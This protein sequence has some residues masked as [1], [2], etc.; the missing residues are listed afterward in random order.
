M[1]ADVF[2]S[3]LN[4]SRPTWGNLGSAAPTIVTAGLSGDED[5]GHGGLVLREHLEVHEA[6]DALVD[7]RVQV[8]DGHRAVLVVHGLQDLAQP[9]LFAEP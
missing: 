4:G 3:L 1:Y 7:E 5:L 6:V 8:A 9:T 2:F